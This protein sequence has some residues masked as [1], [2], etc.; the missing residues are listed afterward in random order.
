[1]TSTMRDLDILGDLDLSVDGGGVR[2]GSA[3]AGAAGQDEMPARR[4]RS[5]AAG[6]RVG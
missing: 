6:I 4:S 3:A 1:M 5:S 2:H